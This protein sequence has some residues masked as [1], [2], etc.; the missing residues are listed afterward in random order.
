MA[1]GASPLELWLVRHG[2]TTRSVAHEV[3][4]WSDPPLTERGREEIRRLSGLFDGRHFD[5]VW[6]SDLSRAVESARLAWGEPVQDPRLREIN[7]GELE[8]RPF[9]DV[10][11]RVAGEVMEF[12]RFEL[13][14]GESLGAFRNRVVAFV[15]Q[16]PPGRHLLFVHGG[17]IR[18]LTQDLGV[19]RFVPTATVVVVDWTVRRVV[20]VAEPSG[21]P[22]VFDGEGAT[23]EQ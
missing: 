6:S 20:R 22:T 9:A 3:A 17:V 23:R 10:D 13:P 12:R 8:E 16:L 19:D 4:G 2:E 14:G 5:G 18:A 15:E 21:A 1:P 7:F 11:P